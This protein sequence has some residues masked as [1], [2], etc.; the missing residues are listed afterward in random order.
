MGGY[1]VESSARVMLDLS[2]KI[3]ILHVDDESGL[4]KIAKQCLE[5]EGSFQVDSALSV[6]EALRKLEKEK[7]DIVVS[8]YQMPGKDGLDFLKTLRRKGNMIPFI[9]FTGKG[10]EE[11]A[12]KAL[13]MG[14]NQYLSKTGETEAVYT[15]LAHSITELARVR[16]AEERLR[17][18]EEKF[19]NIVENSLDVIMLTRPDGVISYMSPACSRVLGYDPEDLVGKQPWIIH[20]ED[21]EKV[22]NAHFQALKGGKGSNLEYRVITKTGEE[23]WISHSWSPAMEDG[24]I[25]LVVSVI[26]DIGNRKKAEDEIRGSEEKFR[27]LFENAND[28]LVFADLSGRIV[29]VNQKAA[30]IAEKRKEEIVGKSFLEIGMVSLHDVPVL[31]EILR[32]QAMG[33]PTGRFECEIEKGDGEKKFIE[34]NSTFILKNNMPTGSFA[35]VRDITERKKT[36]K[37]LNR[38]AVAVDCTVDGIAI[39]DI[40]GY[41]QFVNHAWAQMHGYAKEELIGKH[42][43]VFHTEDQL[44]NDVTPFNEKVLKTG[45]NQGEVGHVKR[46][47]TIFPTLMTT[48]LI[49]DENGGASGFVGTAKDTTEQRNAE[50]ALRKS[51]EKLRAVVSSSPDAISVFDLNGVVVDLNEAAMRLHGFAKKEEILGKS[52][53]DYVVPRDRS[54][55][56]ELFGNT[57]IE[58]HIN[59]AEFSLLTV[60]GRELFAELFAN[61]VRDPS[62]GKPV[63]MVVITRDITERKKTEESLKENKEKFAGLFSGNP[64][65]TVFTD[66][67]MNIVDINPRFESLFGYSLDEIK[68]RN[69]DDVVVPKNLVEE[70][71][72]LGNKSANGYVYHSTTRMRKDGSLIPVSISAAP[73]SIHGTLVGYIGVYKDISEQ[74][75][76]LAQ[77]KGL[78][79][80]NPEAAAYLGPDFCILDVNPR[81]EE[82]FGYSLAEIKG[83]HINETVVPKEKMEEG[84][85]LDQRAGRG[86]VYFDT[87]RMRKDGSLVPVSVSAAPILVE[88]S[89]VGHVA[90]YKDI[91]ELKKVE[92]AMKE[93]MQKIVMMNEKLR[94]VG[95]LTRHDVQNKLTIITGN[96][97]LDKKLTDDHK[98]L[99]SFKEMESA[100]NTIVRIFGF[101]R[102][103]E[104]LGVEELAYIDVEHAVQEAVSLFPNLKG[105]KMANQCHG[106]TVLA[107][108]LLGQLFYNL[109]DNTLKYGEKTTNIR[110]RY[111]EPEGDLLRLIYEDDGV[112]I[113]QDA[114]QKLFTEGYTTG[115]GSGYGLCLINRMVEVY[116]WTIQETGEPGKG[117]QFTMKIPRVNQNGKKN[118][119]VPQ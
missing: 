25:K 35:I 105:V 43:S 18:S 51:E 115:K 37:A 72:M 10:R 19:R 22:R 42:L 20:P 33:R 21:L 93:M 107:D 7:Y 54:R 63:F 34:I 101:A 62:N 90:M 87:F 53:F 4:L 95:D 1:T 69:L 36:E 28:G 73:I 83:K 119:L 89:L 41:V 88:D 55:A 16:K 76:A 6:E 27:T 116:G 67:Q 109:I 56:R 103:Y 46:D 84:N 74:K 47:G 11:V 24:R 82:L 70:G 58:G 96:L 100:C 99:E 113:S 60:D 81:F 79:M 111:E 45:S 12:I 104:K 68:G 23:R 17:D 85:V 65:A 106:L 50:E 31:V 77:F 75:R 13:N 112:G 94:V 8:D 15:E 92:S 117:A 48:A 44:K 14:A 32:Q 110:I 9:M 98:I 78:F 2:E 118:Y 52:S 57:L 66:P 61:V 71:K 38:L 29:D 26:R 59:N 86:Y 30:E 39:A 97:Y 3:R 49:G 102:N 40:K 108:S 80:G 114:K 5:M 91:S 64:E